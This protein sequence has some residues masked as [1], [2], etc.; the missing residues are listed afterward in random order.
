[1][2]CILGIM[3]KQIDKS[4]DYGHCRIEDFQMV[5]LTL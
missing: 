3:H 4:C 1:M 2:S 5:E